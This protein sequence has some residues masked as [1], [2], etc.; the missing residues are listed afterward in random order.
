MAASVSA[1]STAIAAQLKTVGIRTETYLAD[2]FSPPI[3]LVAIDQI[4][5]HDAFGS[6]GLGKY[7]FTVF[8]IVSRADDR[9]GIASLEKYM[10]ASGSLS[11]LAAIEADTTLGAIASA[12]FVKHSGPPASINVGGA[13]YV[14]VP[15]EVEVYAD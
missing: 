2:T 10:S 4:E 1:I 14:S 13:I 12:S 5:Y 3:A 11:I 6:P 8:V 9:A 7:T 15:F